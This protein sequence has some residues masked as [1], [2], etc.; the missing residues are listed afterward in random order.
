MQYLQ[1]ILMCL[2][3]I[4]FNI[5]NVTILLYFR[6][7]NVRIYS[8]QCLV[9]SLLIH[10]SYVLLNVNMPCTVLKL[11]WCLKFGVK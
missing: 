10:H 2:G 4:R 8:S 11:C 3:I 6:D 5:D 9:I 7:R 1:N